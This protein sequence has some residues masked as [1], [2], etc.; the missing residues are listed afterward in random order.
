MFKM[1]SKNDRL[2]DEWLRAVSRAANDLS[3]HQRDGLLADL[4]EHIATE[5][6]ELRPETEA[7]LRT[8]LDRLGDPAG[9]VTEAR[10]GAPSPTRHGVKATSVALIAVI[11]MAIILLCAAGLYFGMARGAT[12][13]HP[14]PDAPSPRPTISSDR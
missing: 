5:R 2:V 7:G 10:R 12:G 1:T 11:V 9:I 8:I 4:R 3:P 6:A 14:V 13:D